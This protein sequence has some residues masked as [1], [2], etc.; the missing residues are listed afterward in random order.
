MH[1]L[2]EITKH[3]FFQFLNRD[4][5]INDFEQ[6]VYKSS[7]MLEIELGSEFHLNL[8]SF[9]YHQKD[10][11][12]QLDAILKSLINIKEFDIW[13]IKE[14]LTN[15]IDNKIDLVLATRK[16][17]QLYL[18]TGENLIPIKLGIG[19]ESVL[20][21]VP[22]PSEYIQWQPEALE[23]KLKKINTYRDDILHDSKLFL[24]TLNEK[25]LNDT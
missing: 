15:I 22:I 19:Y 24:G 12:H 11:F 20:D 2:S 9:N 5:L 1:K 16:L 7:H 13:R 17:R 10:N 14:L 18:D 25:K 8:I 6:W 3:T 21:D 4:L 23:Q